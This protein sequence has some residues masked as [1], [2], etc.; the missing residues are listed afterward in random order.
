MKIIQALA[1]EREAEERQ[2]QQLINQ[3]RLDHEMAKRLALETGGHVD[4]LILPQAKGETHRQSKYDLSK[5]RYADLRDVINTSN[6]NETK[7]LFPFLT[8]LRI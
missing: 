6:G 2:L 8:F 1:A 3:E 7:I 5:W 4:D